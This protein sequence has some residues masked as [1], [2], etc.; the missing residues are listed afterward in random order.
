MDSDLA[1]AGAELWRRRR[2]TWTQTG[3]W[4]RRQGRWRASSRGSRAEQLGRRGRRRHGL[5]GAA[6]A[7]H[8]AANCRAGLAGGQGGR[9]QRS[10]GSGPQSQSTRHRSGRR[11]L[12][13]GEM[14]ELQGRPRG[15]ETKPLHTWQRDGERVSRG[16]RIQSRS[17]ERTPEEG[18]QAGG[19]SSSAM[20]AG[21]ES[22]GHLSGD[23]AYYSIV[24]CP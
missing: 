14:A 1:R 3:R 18:D 8:T 5:L 17:S 16:G 7:C 23:E 21:R 22:S 10:G 4:R 20:V 11:H 2:R 6:S 19:G 9:G 15:Q 13:Q 24:A 12:A